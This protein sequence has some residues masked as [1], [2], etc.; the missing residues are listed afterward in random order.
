MVRISYFQ[1]LHLSF[2]KKYNRLILGFDKVCKSIVIFREKEKKKKKEKKRSYYYP[3]RRVMLYDLCHL[4]YPLCRV[5]TVTL[6]VGFLCWIITWIYFY[7][8]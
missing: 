4:Y 7:L 2:T 1:L 8:V 5:V 6:F 3:F